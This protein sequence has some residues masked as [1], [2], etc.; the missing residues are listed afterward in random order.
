MAFQ[1]AGLNLS[2]LQNLTPPSYSDFNLSTTGVGLI[3]DIPDKANQVVSIGGVS[4]LGISVMVTLFF[5]LVFK[6]GD[7]L[8]LNGQPYSHIRTVGI[9]AGVVGAIGTQ[10]VMIG[11]FTEFFHVVI[12]LGILLVTTLWTFYEDKR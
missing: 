3:N 4:Y 11:Y 1:K 6:L 8:E 12:F 10:M 2:K 9:A 7:F 5:Y